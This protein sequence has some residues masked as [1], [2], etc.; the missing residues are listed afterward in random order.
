MNQNQ[1]RRQ[2][3]VIYTFPFVFDRISLIGKDILSKY[4]KSLL[5]ISSYKTNTSNIRSAIKGFSH[6]LQY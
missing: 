1:F 4:D 6:C 3:L 2:N 5:Y